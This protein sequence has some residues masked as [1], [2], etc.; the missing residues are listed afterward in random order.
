MPDLTDIDGSQLA[1][2]IR[3]AIFEKAR[4]HG[5]YDA[6]W[7]SF[8]VASVEAGL[9][10]ARKLSAEPY[11][12]RIAF[13]IAAA[14]FHSLLETLGIRRP[15]E[16]TVAKVDWHN[17]ASEPM[18]SSAPKMALIWPSEVRTIENFYDP[19]NLVE[20]VLQTVTSDAP[21]SVLLI[22]ERK[23]GKTS[24]L[25]VLHNCLTETNKACKALYI[26]TLSHSHS[27]ESFAKELLGE[28]CDKL[29]ISQ[30]D[31]N[32][33]QELAQEQDVGAF[34]RTLLRLLGN[35]K[36]ILFIDEM[37]SMVRHLRGK[38]DAEQILEL[39]YRLIMGVEGNVR[40]VA[41]VS[42]PTV[43]RHGNY[44]SEILLNL[45]SVHIPQLLAFQTGE[46]VHKLKLPVA[47]KFNE[48]AVQQISDLSGGVIYLIKFIFKALELYL[49]IRPNLVVDAQV[50]TQVVEQV[51]SPSSS[52]HNARN[53]RNN[54]F[55]TLNN[56]FERHFSDV[57][58][59]F[60]KQ[61]LQTS[62]ELLVLQEDEL[63]REA[64]LSLANRGYV[65]FSMKEEQLVFQWRIGLW[66][67]FLKENYRWEW[68]NIQSNNNDLEINEDTQLISIGGVDFPGTPQERKILFCLGRYAGKLV[69][70]DVLATEAWGSEDED[71]I[72]NQTILTAISRLRKKLAQKAPD[73]TFIETVSGA[74]FIL[75]NVKYIQ[76]GR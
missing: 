8:L 43:L 63:L 55:D 53:I 30:K 76:G 11:P 23:S 73:I 34:V 29:P 28:A 16:V 48:R 41:T 62:G 20:N 19:T 2:P 69:A 57:E 27:L 5:M 59:Q 36:L 39:I 60:A 12:Q 24:T 6:Y 50:V 66:H 33:L 47:L 35:N 64:G 75:R 14:R 7:V 22:G 65:G 21:Q 17:I 52:D 67:L 26:N 49:R 32:L 74:G 13:L 38:S 72:P 44:G 71:A 10:F 70:Y 61:L 15:D 18:H 46:L 58:K 45:M 56:I 40:L 31:R 51:V 54:L 1:S 68:L 42:D 37:D 25:F 4:H 3:Q 9:N